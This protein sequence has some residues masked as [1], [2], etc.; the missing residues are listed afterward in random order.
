MLLSKAW[1]LIIIPFTFVG[2]IAPAFLPPLGPPEPPFP[3]A[4]PAPCCA[5]LVIRYKMAAPKL[6]ANK[7]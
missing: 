6:R 4:P 3:P 7:I 5:F 2:G 1:L